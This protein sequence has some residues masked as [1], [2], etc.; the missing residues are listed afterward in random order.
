V[1]NPAGAQEPAA[2]KR[3]NPTED[4]I[5]FD[6]RWDVA[7][8]RAD[9]F[10]EAN[11]VGGAKLAK[12]RRG[13]V[14]RL[15]ITGTPKPGYHTYPLTQ[16]APKQD[17]AGL[18]F[19]TYQDVPGLKPLWPVEESPPEFVTED[20]GDGHFPYLEFRKPF[21]WK[22]DIL[23]QPDAAPGP[24]KLSFV[25]K[26]QVCDE[27]QC[28]WGEHTLSADIEVTADPPVTPAA[29]L[30]QRPQTPPPVRVVTPPEPPAAAGATPTAAAPVAAAPDRSGLWAFILSGIF[31]GAISLVTPCVFPMIPI[32]VSFFLK[33]S[34]KENHRPVAMALVYAATIVTV[35]TIAA[36]TLLSLFRALSTH[37]AMNFGLGALFV[38]F[39]L[40]LFGMYE[41]ELPQGLAQFTSSKQGRGGLVGTMFMALT[42]TIISFACV[43]PFLGGFGGTANVQ[44]LTLLDRTLGGL[45]FSLTF[46]SPFFVLALFPTLLKAMPKSGNWL[47]SVKVVMGFL[48]LAAAI[49]FFRQGELVFYPTPKL[50][51]YDLALG[52]YVALSLLCGLYLLNVYRL[53]H[54]TPSDHL[55]VPQLVCS[56]L[57]LGLGFYLLPALFKVGPSA[58]NQRP[59]GVVFAWLD[60][61][62]LPEE[63][64]AH[65]GPGAVAGRNGETDELPWTG[66]LQEGLKDALPKRRLVFVDFTG[67]TCTNCKINERDVFPKPEIRELMKQYSLVQLYTDKVPNRLYGSAER[68]ALG[69]GTDRQR[70]DARANL[71]FQRAKFDTE[72]LPLY[73]IL[74]P[75]SDGTFREIARYAEGK[76]N[77]VAG[78]TQFLKQP[79]D[80]RAIGP[81]AEAGGR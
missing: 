35:L 11:R 42:F 12:V 73:V 30:K 64:E 66:N 58:A 2:K 27:H 18:C 28:V 51:T 15:I 75:Q 3:R 49:K 59:T 22:Q 8:D 72:Q 74:E 17:E 23:V 78:F 81:R 77:D 39:A 55:S 54:D 45:A 70:Q 46:A 24:K 38:F 76:I 44:Q 71:D 37:W 57:F 40:S 52:L 14:A 26:A 43:A 69:D 29:D 48:E 63:E 50:F 41:I 16:R 10:S 20:T 19:I 5:S 9:A 34:E 25:I 4:R 61:F 6:V 13:E 65:A 33:Q 31:W 60:S 47:N 32:T 79:L 68:A 53:P 36:V 7:P 67:V 21:T 56:L 1:V 80:A 62:L